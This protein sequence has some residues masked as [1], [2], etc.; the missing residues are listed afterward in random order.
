MR[1]IATVTTSAPLASWAC[2]MISSDG[3]FPVP[4][5]SRERHSYLPTR[6]VSVSVCMLSSGDGDD[7]L[8]SVAVVQQPRG[9]VHPRHDVIVERDRGSVA[10]RAERFQ[11]GVD[12]R[13]VGDF[14]RLTVDRDR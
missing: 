7:D 5:K 13:T 1:R 12:R 3:Y 4:T 9:M 11:Q 10:P 2:C 6:S 14:A 8:D